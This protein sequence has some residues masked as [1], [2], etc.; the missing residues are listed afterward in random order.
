AATVQGGRW[1]EHANAP[2][3]CLLD[4]RNRFGQL[5]GTRCEPAPAWPDVIPAAEFQGISAALGRAEPPGLR[6]SRRQEPGWL[7][8]AAHH[9]IGTLACP[10]SRGL[11][12]RRRLGRQPTERALDGGG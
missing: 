12:R 7:R 11:V 10:I 4:E 3:N 5:A 9:A 2:V 1:R 8:A 6:R